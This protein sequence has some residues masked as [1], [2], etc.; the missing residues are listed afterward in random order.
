M[1]VHE[2][3]N[4]V[5]KCGCEK[6]EVLPNQDER[7][8]YAYHIH[9]PNLD[10]EHHVQLAE[11]A[12]IQYYHG[13]EECHHAMARFDKLLLGIPH[14]VNGASLGFKG[15]GIMARQGWTLPRLA[16]FALITQGWAMVFVVLWLF[17]HPGDLQNAFAPAM[18]SLSLVAVF[19]AIPD[20]FR[21]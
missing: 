8:C 4:R 2:P 7:T 16:A 6:S 14:R 1:R 3:E 5:V 9:P 17:Y 20:V 18:Y 13:Y 12:L 11:Q 19:V 21:S 10:E 15:Y